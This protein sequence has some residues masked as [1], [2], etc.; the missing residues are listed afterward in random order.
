MNITSE[1]S[2]Q[3]IYEAG[4]DAGLFQHEAPFE[5][6][7]VERIAAMWEPKRTCEALAVEKVWLRSWQKP[8][9]RS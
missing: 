1:S 4:I 7:R 9:E 5:Q 2:E 6:A 8:Q 3:E